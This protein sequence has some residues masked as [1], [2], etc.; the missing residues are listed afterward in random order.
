M[1]FA[2][3]SDYR[4]LMVVIHG[5]AGWLLINSGLVVFGQF[6]AG[7]CLLISLMSVIRSPKPHK[8]HCKLEYVQ[9]EWCLLTVDGSIER[10]SSHHVLAELGLFF[11][12][13]LSSSS[14]QKTMVVFFDQISSE[15]YRCL[16]L[17]ETIQ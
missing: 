14:Q 7:L 1:V 11:L 15:N 10:Y 13:K 8:N 5:I 4:R 16:R 3:S 2:E 12:L 17:L 6:V 9:Q